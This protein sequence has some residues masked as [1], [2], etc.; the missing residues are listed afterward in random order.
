MGVHLLVAGAENLEAG[1]ELNW[2]KW[3][4]LEVEVERTLK[5]SWKGQQ[6][7][8]EEAAGRLPNQADH[9][10]FLCLA[11]FDFACPLLSVSRGL[12]FG[13]P[14]NLRQPRCEL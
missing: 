11:N 1:G 14:Q 7:W 10:Y 8:V 6:E 9:E 12:R 3:V 2:W 4:T 5:Q 13:F